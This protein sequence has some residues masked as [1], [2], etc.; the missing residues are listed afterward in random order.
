MCVGGRGGREGERGERERGGRGREGGEG[1]GGRER[2]RE[3]EREKE[4]ESGT[5]SLM[6]HHV[7]CLSSRHLR[8]GREVVDKVTHYNVDRN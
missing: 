7:V 3:R 2:E 8:N 5:V 6:Q 1:E 4:K